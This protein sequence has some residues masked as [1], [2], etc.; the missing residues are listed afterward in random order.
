MRPSLK[1]CVVTAALLGLAA[2]AG[3][4]REEGMEL[5]LGLTPTRSRATG[6]SGPRTLVND[7]GTR[8]AFSR[9]LVTLGSVELLPCEETGW[10]RLLREL[11]PVGTA[12]AHS[13][14]SPRRLGVPHVLDLGPS[15]GDV[16]P[17]GTLRPAPGRY[18]RARLTFQPADS[19][20]EGLAGA[21]QGP[22]PVDMVGRSLHARG[23]VSSTDGTD[24]WPFEVSMAGQTSVDVVLDGVMLSEAQPRASLV[25]TLAWDTWL[26]GVSAELPPGRVDLL[27]NVARS[28]SHQPL[29]V[30]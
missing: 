29:T 1:T 14:S 24:A 12:H 7:K 27:G 18:C 30:P 5:H 22:E 4:E 21:A 11:S 25:F 17:L 9:A 26:D 10:R 6:E 19:D 16:T 20:A 8:A 13:V 3:G 2:C 15:D 28:A 23:T